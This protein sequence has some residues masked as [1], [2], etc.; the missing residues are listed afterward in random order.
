MRG[1]DWIRS[2]FRIQ[3]APAM[4]GIQARDK[5][6][7]VLNKNGLQAYYYLPASGIDDRELAEALRLLGDSGYIVT[8]RTTGDLTGCVVPAS[9][10]SQER[11]EKR[12]AQFRII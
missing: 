6:L 11:A 2:L 12:R 8:N 3:P 7:A 10:S 1:F 9:M 4:V 5:A